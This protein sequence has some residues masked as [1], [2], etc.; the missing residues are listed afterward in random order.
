M[1]NTCEHERNFGGGG[2]ANTAPIYFLPKNS[3][4]LAAELKR[5]K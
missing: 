2:E 4:L 3:F 1:D 5:G